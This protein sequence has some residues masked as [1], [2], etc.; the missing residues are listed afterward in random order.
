MVLDWLK[1]RPEEIKFYWKSR[2]GNYEFAA[3]GMAYGF[4]SY[5]EVEPLLDI[6][7][8][9]RVICA[10]RFEAT[11]D[12]P[13]WE[14]FSRYPF[15]IPQLEMVRDGSE[16]FEISYQTSYS[17]TGLLRYAGN[18]DL[19][20]SNVEQALAA[21]E[22]GTLTKIVLAVREEIVGSFNAWELLGRLRNSKHSAH[23]F[24][25]QMKENHVFIGASPE[26]LF[27]REGK[28]ITTEALAGTCPRGQNTSEDQL[29]AEH[30]LQSSKELREHSHVCHHIN[31][32]F[33]RLCTDHGALGDRYIVT[34]PSVHHVRQDFAGILRDGISDGDILNDLH[35]T[36]AVCGVPREAALETIRELEGF[37]RGLYSGAIGYITKKKSE[38]AVAIRS[39]FIDGSTC[40]VY[41]GAGIVAGSVADAEWHEIQNKLM[42][43]KRALGNF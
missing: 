8:N 35:P 12:S 15:F 33:Q 20:I 1:N 24:F 43:M 10:L 6:L 26:L 11:M 17:H 13:Q 23:Y 3:V 42:P 22:K 38:F 40:Y 9:V 2:D 25:F 32:V 16:C 41:A 36:P 21:I 19:F 31:T 30:L 39:A 37:D 4:R 28:K 27:R 34:L 29:L 5:A 7:P 14:E 18:N